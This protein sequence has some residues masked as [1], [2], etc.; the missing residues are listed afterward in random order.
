MLYLRTE[1]AAS[2]YFKM[3]RDAGRPSGGGQPQAQ[4]DYSEHAQKERRC[5]ADVS[6]YMCKR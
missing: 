3:Q 2:G 5:T 1:T 6:V 4:Y